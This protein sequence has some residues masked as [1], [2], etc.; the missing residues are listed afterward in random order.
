M[1]TQKT[2]RTGQK[3]LNSSL[4]PAILSSVTTFAIAYMNLI[5]NNKAPS[6]TLKGFSF[7][8]ELQIAIILPIIALL[9]F[10]TFNSIRKAVIKYNDS[11]QEPFSGI[12]GYSYGAHKFEYILDDFL[13]E[14]EFSVHSDVYIDSVEGPF[15][16][17]K[18]E[19]EC[20]AELVVRKTF[21][22][23][24]RYTCELCGKTRKIKLSQ[25]SL[26][27]RTE[28]IVLALLKQ[29]KR[30]G[31]LDEYDDFRRY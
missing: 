25:W 17:G 3:I 4:T 18:S 24:Y 19:N 8:K 7:S 23:N 28:R 13:F 26:K 12:E 16:T 29:K 6:I 5:A 31:D 22:G 10:L 1:K 9:M 15:C 14:N 2:E 20:G 30:S 11:Q 27:K 21:F